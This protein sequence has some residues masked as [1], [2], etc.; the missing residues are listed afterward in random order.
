LGGLIQ[1]LFLLRKIWNSVFL[2]GFAYRKVGKKLKVLLPQRL[3]KSLQRSSWLKDRRKNLPSLSLPQ[4]N[5][6]PLFQTLLVRKKNSKEEFI[7]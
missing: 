5:D 1:N 2:P 7:G 6:F 4:A 3:L